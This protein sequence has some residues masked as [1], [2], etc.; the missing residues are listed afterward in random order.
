MK[1]DEPTVCT[2]HTHVTLT[3]GWDLWWESGSSQPVSSSMVY[4]LVRSYPWI[5]SLHLL[6][7]PRTC[8][9]AT[10]MAELLCAAS[11][12]QHLPGGILGAIA[13]TWI[14]FVW[15][16]CSKRVQKHSKAKTQGKAKFKNPFWLLC[17]PAMAVAKKSSP[18][19][20]SLFW[21]SESDYLMQQLSSLSLPHS[22]QG[23]GNKTWPKAVRLPPL[24]VCKGQV[25]LS[26]HIFL[27]SLWPARQFTSGYDQIPSHSVKMSKVPGKYVITFWIWRKQLMKWNF[28]A[29]CSV[30]WYVVACLWAEVWVHLW[31]KEFLSFKN[32]II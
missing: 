31:H 27:W 18:L 10:R 3:E 26:N 1:V 22:L 14:R 15:V 16:W 12:W 20:Q 23:S 9:L 19:S 4:S 21:S 7:E 6:I 32:L 2:Q 29:L 25:Y 17:E 11:S 24:T 28:L 8:P 13:S 5:K 30:G